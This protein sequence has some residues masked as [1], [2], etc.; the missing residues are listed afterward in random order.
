MGGIIENVLRPHNPLGNLGDY[1]KACRLFRWEQVEEQF[2][3]SQTGRVNIAYEAIDRHAEDPSR[4]H[5][6]ALIYSG[7]DREEMFTY[8]QMR[9][10]SNKFANVLR[11]LGVERGDRVYLLL[12]RI[13]EM[14][15]ALVG[16][17]KAGAVI[18]P[19][20]DHYR[21]DAVRER[22][23]DSRGRVVLTVPELVENIPFNSLPDLEHVILV[24]D[25]WRGMASW[26]KSFYREMSM[27]SDC[28][29]TAWVGREH[30]LL[31]IY[32]AGAQGRPMGLI[33]VHDCMLGYLQ[34][35]RWVLDLRDDDVVWTVAQ[36]GWL[37]NIVYGAF[38]PWLCGVELFV[39]SQVDSAH[40]IYQA[41]QRRGVTVMYTYPGVYRWMM[42][43][44]EEAAS[45]Y[46]LGSLRH[47]CSALEPL[48]PDLIYWVLKVLKIPIHDTWWMAETGYII[49]AN[50]PSMSIKPGFMGRP[51]PGIDV[52]VVDA[53]GNPLPP[54]TMG[55]LAIR[56]G[57]P[58]MA[59]GVWG[60]RERY[61][62]Y[63]SI[64]PW[65]ITGDQAYRDFNGYLYYQGRMDDVIVTR[66]GRVS[67]YEVEEVLTSHP[68]VAEAGVIRIQGPSGGKKIKAFIALRSPHRPTELLRAKILSFVQERLSE[69][70]MPEE[71]EFCSSLPKNNSNKIIRRVLKA[72][73]MGFPVGK[74]ENLKQE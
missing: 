50:F 52:Q 40:D 53:Q 14:Y 3:W 65:F 7:A 19:L 22:M 8:D 39:K 21:E 27:A 42:E 66:G 59:R 56:T 72:W 55:Q 24:G 54:F 63:F 15:I 31:L 12:P 6:S 37:M 60:D 68:A 34:T 26:E 61:W 74:L 45:A 73:E 67:P 36:P 10:L 48:T 38:A 29:P 16:C 1:E 51:L 49:V 28:F 62:R 69:E 41:I 57:W 4:A 23:L 5:K 43:A 58:G 9:S 71:I 64:P 13:P 2:S 17:A 33:H 47:C 32:T 44:G 25:P 35:A 46:D 70:V 30:P 20:Y 11:G 18:A